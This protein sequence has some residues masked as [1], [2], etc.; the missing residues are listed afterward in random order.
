MN[1]M[2]S[3]V[4]SIRA[5]NVLF[6]NISKTFLSD[7]KNYRLDDIQ[8]CGHIALSSSSATVA[9]QIVGVSPTKVL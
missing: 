7:M 8:L 9:Q 4:H 2:I 1:S 6:W 5:V 3:A